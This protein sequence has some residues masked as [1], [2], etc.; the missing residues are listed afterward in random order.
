GVTQAIFPEGGLSR[1]GRLRPRKFGLLSYMVSGF[2]PLG[3]RDVGS[4]PAAAIYAGVREDGMLTSAA[5][6]EPAKKRGFGSNAAVSA[7]RSR[8]RD[9]RGFAHAD[10]APS[11]SGG[12]R[13]LSRQPER[14]D[15]VEILRQ[16][17][18]AFV[19]ECGAGVM[20]GR[21]WGGSS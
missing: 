17:H 9:F 6:T 18:R 4:I 2:D 3:P 21:Q 15:P 14:T 20:I 5:K 16:R 13:Q 19:R 10:A 1:D 12:G 7:R 11:C 8:L